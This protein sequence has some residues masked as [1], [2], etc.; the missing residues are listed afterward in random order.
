MKFAC[1][2]GL[3]ALT[4]TAIAQTPSTDAKPAAQEATKPRPPLKLKL[5]EVEPAR[6]RITFGA[7]EEKPKKDDSASSNLP[8]L[9]GNPDA[10]WQQPSKD[11]FPQNTGGAQVVR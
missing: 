6:P 7:K 2:I 3:F 5:D 9:G 10:G 11:V 8:G 4:G 1:V